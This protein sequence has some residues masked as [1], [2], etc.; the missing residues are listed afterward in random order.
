MKKNSE[1]TRPDDESCDEETLEEDISIHIFSTSATMVG[2]CLTVIGLFKLI[3]Q[4]KA[5]GTL[6]DDLL[7]IDASLFLIPNLTPVVDAFTKLNSNAASSD[8]S[9]IRSSDANDVQT[10]VLHG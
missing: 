9:V 2:V 3:I 10:S 4:L 8:K 6:G 7:A 5:I 1:L